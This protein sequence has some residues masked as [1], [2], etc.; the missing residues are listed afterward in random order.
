MSSIEIGH[1]RPVSRPALPLFS[2]LATGRYRPTRLWNKAAFRAKFALRSLLAPGDTYRLLQMLA[3]LPQ[4][5]AILRCQPRLPCRLHHPYLSV[6]LSRPQIVDA[7]TDHYRLLNQLL[8]IS[9]FPTLYAGQALTL[10]T[11]CGK[12]DQTYSLR[13]AM[14]EKLGKEGDLSIAL[15]DQQNILLAVCTFSFIDYQG[16]RTL[17]IGGLQGSSPSL[18]HSHTQTATKACHGLFPKRLLADALCELA[19]I[20]RCTQILAVGNGSHIYSHWRYRR[21]KQTQML[22]DYDGFWLSLS[23]TPTDDGHFRL[24]LPPQRKPLE[25]IPSKKRAEYRR[26]Y[27]LLDEMQRA[28]CASL[29]ATA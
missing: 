26:R 27:Q 17:F 29:G 12:N 10:A 19:R 13:L 16:A 11:L 25:S 2:R 20:A 18:P 8:P 7:L 15:C 24:P 22:A 23:A 6:R 3:E 1:A 4:R 9:Q 21:K 5:D 14:L 28:V